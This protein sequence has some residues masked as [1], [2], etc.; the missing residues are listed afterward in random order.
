MCIV[1][2]NNNDSNTI[3]IDDDDDGKTNAKSDGKAV[4]KKQKMINNNIGADADAEHI[5]TFS[6]KKLKNIMAAYPKAL[7]LKRIRYDT[8]KTNAVK[9][10]NDIKKLKSMIKMH[11]TNRFTLIDKTVKNYADVISHCVTSCDLDINHL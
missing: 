8:K 6:T 9:I 4:C 10:C 3:V 5:I 2:L 11:G 1:V 7:L